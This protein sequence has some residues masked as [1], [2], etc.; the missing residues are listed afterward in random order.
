MVDQYRNMR[1]IIEKDMHLIE[2]AGKVMRDLGREPVTMPVRGGT[3]GAT[4]SFMG[5][6]CPNIGTGGY[7]AHGPYEHVTVEGMEFVTE[8]IMGIA[9]EY[10]KK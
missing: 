7:A 6:P 3:D 4:L 5:L 9:G 1:E 10:A 2:T 8:L